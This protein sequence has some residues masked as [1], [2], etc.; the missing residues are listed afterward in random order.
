MVSSEVVRTEIKRSE[1]FL[2][3][4]EGNEIGSPFRRQEIRAGAARDMEKGR[5]HG[6]NIRK[7]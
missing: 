3:L 2:V 1:E 4:E 5:I 7:N 6:N